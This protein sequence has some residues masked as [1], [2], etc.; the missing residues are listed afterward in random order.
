M[1]SVKKKGLIIALSA[2]CLLCAGVATT[3]L[4]KKSDLRA[5]AATV[6]GVEFSDLYN[7]GETVVLPGGAEIEYQGK[8]LAASKSYLVFPDGNARVKDE[9]T[10]DQY[11]CYG[12]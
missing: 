10:L 8:N 11:G 1:S 5:E 6:V 4:G 7:Y 12:L 3:S 2:A 9:Y